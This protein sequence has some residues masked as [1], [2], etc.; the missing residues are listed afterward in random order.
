MELFEN[1]CRE[2]ENLD[3]Y[4]DYAHDVVSVVIKKLSQVDRGNRYQIKIRIKDSWMDVEYGCGLG[5]KAIPNACAVLSSLISDAMWI[6]GA[7]SFDEFCGDTGSSSDSIQNFRMYHA[8]VM[9]RMFLTLVFGSDEFESLS[10]QVRERDRVDDDTG[11]KVF[12]DPEFECDW[13]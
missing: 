12:K 6:N 5:N 3:D 11:F 13:S 2:C 7:D 1:L 4:N 10:D 9:T 8:C